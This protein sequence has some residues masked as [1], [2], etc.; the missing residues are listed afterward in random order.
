MYRI[1]S[2]VFCQEG[3]GSEYFGKIIKIDNKQRFCTVELIGTPPKYIGWEDSNIGDKTYWHVYF[4]FIK[5]V[6][7]C[8]NVIMETE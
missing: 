7:N 5:K 3:R 4:D 1:G 6:K 8:A 2:I